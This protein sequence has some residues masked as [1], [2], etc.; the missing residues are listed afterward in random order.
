MRL[1]FSSDCSSAEFA[2]HFEYCFDAGSV[3]PGNLLTHIHQFCKMVGMAIA[4]YGCA[5]ESIVDTTLTR[6]V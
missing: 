5:P 1:M 6:F 4:M 2:N 3:Q